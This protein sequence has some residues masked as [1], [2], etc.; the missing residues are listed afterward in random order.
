MG[1]FLNTAIIL[2]CNETTVKSAIEKLEKTSDLYGLSATKCQFKEYEKGVQV[3]FNDG[4]TGYD[5]LAKA[6]SADTNQP[7]LL[8]YIYDDDFWGYYFYENGKEIDCFSPKPDYFDDQISEEEMQHNAGKKD[9]I[10]Q[11]FNIDEKEIENYLVVWTEELEEQACDDN[12]KAYEDDEA[13]Q[14]DCWQI[15][16]FMKKLGYPYEMNA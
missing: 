4:C 7:T 2:N 12:L 5:E 8:L 3:L 11:Y 9:V 13:E 15:A 14:C 1:L 10:A 6:L 16:D